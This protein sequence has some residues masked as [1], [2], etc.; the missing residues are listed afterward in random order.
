MNLTNHYRLGNGA[1]TVGYSANGEASDWM[2]V[3]FGIVAT[4][5]EL[6]TIDR[7]SREHYIL[8]KDVVLDVIE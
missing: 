2:L 3:N 1:I 7:R 4:S 8:E 5:P 6:G